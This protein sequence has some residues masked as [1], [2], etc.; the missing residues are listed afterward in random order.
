[1]L[2]LAA[3]RLALAQNHKKKKEYNFA[4]W[5]SIDLDEGEMECKNDLVSYHQIIKRDFLVMHI[6]IIFL[7][8]R[9]R[10]RERE[11]ECDFVHKICR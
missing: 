9:M 5:I 1:V 8:L 10:E 7:F 3:I 6:C 2:P 4:D 11:S